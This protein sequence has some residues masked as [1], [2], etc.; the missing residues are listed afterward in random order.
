MFRLFYALNQN[1]VVFVLLVVLFNKGVIVAI[2]LTTSAFVM[3]IL[4]AT[5][6]IMTKVSK[7]KQGKH[8]NAHVMIMLNPYIETFVF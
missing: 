7:T 6:V 8:L 3:L 4:L 2:V 5:Y 1:N